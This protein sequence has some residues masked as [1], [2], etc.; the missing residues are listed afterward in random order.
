VLGKLSIIGAVAAIVMISKALSA[1]MGGAINLASTLG[2]LLMPALPFE[3]PF[4]EVSLARI[5]GPG[6]RPVRQ[7]VGIVWP[8]QS[9]ADDGAQPR[10][11]NFSSGW[12]LGAA[13]MTSDNSL[14]L[15]LRHLDELERKLD[16]VLEELRTP[17]AIGYSVRRG[18]LPRKD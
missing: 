18:N 16:H 14:S 2:V 9:R 1:Q 5:S 4:S 6:A 10:W 11:T 8:P 7:V 17:A 12:G 13:L 15:I 3:A